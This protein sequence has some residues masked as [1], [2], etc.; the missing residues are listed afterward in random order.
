MFGELRGLVE[1]TKRHSSAVQRGHEK[2]RL[3]IRDFYAC[4]LDRMRPLAVACRFL[5]QDANR[6]Q[7]ALRVLHIRKIHGRT[8]RPNRSGSLARTTK[9]HTLEGTK[10]YGTFLSSHSRGRCSK[11]SKGSASAAITMNSEIPRL[12]VFVAEGKTGNENMN[13]VCHKTVTGV[14]PSTRAISNEAFQYFQHV[15]KSSRRA[16]YCEGTSG[17]ASVDFSTAMSSKRT[18]SE[19][20]SEVTTKAA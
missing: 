11:I 12:S 19:C 7:N 18:I 1:N 5:I 8:S 3:Y 20:A 4:L 6:V 15:L 9:P 17:I 2:A 14:L 10:T 16:S 13:S